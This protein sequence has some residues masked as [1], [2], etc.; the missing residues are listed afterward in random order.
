MKY[1]LFLQQNAASPITGIWSEP[2]LM[3]CGHPCLAYISSFQVTTST[4]Y[5]FYFST[6]PQGSRGATSYLPH[7]NLATVNRDFCCLVVFWGLLFLF[8]CLFFKYWLWFK[9]ISW[10]GLVPYSGYRGY[11]KTLWWNRIF[12]CKLQKHKQWYQYFSLINVSKFC[13]E[14]CLTFVYFM[15]LSFSNYLKSRT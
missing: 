11:S 3:L 13:C 8:V 10:F 2:L 1:T 12:L 15:V 14:I 4:P 9:L 7:S 6:G 5:H